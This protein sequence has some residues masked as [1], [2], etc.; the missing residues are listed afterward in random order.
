M[1]LTI[2]I[3]C[4]NRP[5]LAKL[6][7]ESALN[8]GCQTFELIISDHSTNDEVES[9][10][11]TSFPSVNYVRRPTSLSHLEH[12]NV[13][14][15]EAN[16]DF[17][18]LFHDDD[19]MHSSFVQEMLNIIKK[20]PGAV[21]YACNAY[22]ENNGLIAPSLSFISRVES[23][24]ISKP[25]DLAERYFCR[26]HSGI[27]PNPSYIY[28]R[29]MACNL[30]FDVDGGKYA[31]VTLLLELL[32]KGF[33]FWLNKPLITY[34]IHGN[35]LSSIESLPDRI[36]FLGYL[37]KHK[38]VFGV[39]V[40]DDYR[41]SF[42]Y[43]NWLTDCKNKNKNMKVIRLFLNTYYFRHYC[44]F[45]TYKALINR[46]LNKFFCKTLKTIK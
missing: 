42:I 32:Q 2:F 19:V 14:I 26:N 13:C 10:V 28:R 4:R 7:I 12:F 41:Y 45:S 17:Y 24:L 15:T 25:R 44:Q 29:D 9:M 39:N 37:K 43:K 20:Y 40:L 30:L 31:D 3:L 1:T 11:K 38:K 18:C 21:A 23:E 5:E 8:Q 16:K 46:Q 34:R 6:A 35:N 36:R 22:I 33:I 27:A